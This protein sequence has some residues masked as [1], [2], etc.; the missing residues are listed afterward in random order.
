MVLPVIKQQ[1]LDDLDQ[2]SPEMQRRAAD[3]VHRLVSPLPKD[4]SG[5]DLLRFAGTL[6]DESAREMI[7]AIEQGCERVDLDAW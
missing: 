6:D 1:I 7:A 2:L 3:L 5:R 4:A